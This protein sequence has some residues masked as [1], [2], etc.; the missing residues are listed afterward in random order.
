[1]ILHRTCLLP[2]SV[3]TTAMNCQRDSTTSLSIAV[4]RQ[5]VGSGSIEHCKLFVENMRAGRNKVCVVRLY[6]SG[7]A[8]KPLD[9]TAAQLALAD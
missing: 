4:G 9:V 5:W 1:M 7:D 6:R 8:S 3:G 2:V